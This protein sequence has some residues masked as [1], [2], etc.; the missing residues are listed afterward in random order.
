[1]TSSHIDR[2]G[3][4]PVGADSSNHARRHQDAGHDT[5]TAGEVIV[6]GRRFRL[7][8]VE[9]IR[10]PEQRTA[11]SLLTGREIQ[12]VS[13]VA[14]GRVNKQIAC[15][16]HISEWTVSTHIRRIFC[17]LGVDT[18]AAMVSKCSPMLVKHS[19]DQGR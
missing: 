11:A 18:R 15:D 10:T 3:K 17:K 16:L 19:T 4:R 2:N 14:E 1:M 8:P 13:L 6:G 12:I 5:L 7:V 9:E